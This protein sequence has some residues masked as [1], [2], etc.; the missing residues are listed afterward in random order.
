MRFSFAESM[1]P[2]EKIRDGNRS[3]VQG[4]ANMGFRRNGEE[5]ITVVEMEA[6][7]AIFTAKKK[8]KAMASFAGV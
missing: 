1:W 8:T 7:Y 5:R 2:A 6:G 4:T 3:A